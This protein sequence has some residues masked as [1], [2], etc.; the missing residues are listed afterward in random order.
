M[1]IR[2]TLRHLR[3]GMLPAVALLAA[4][5]GLATAASLWRTEAARANDRAF[6]ER[7]DLQRRLAGV[8]E[9][10]GELRLGSALFGRLAARGIIG[11]ESRLEWVEQFQRVR[12]QRRLFE[13]R[14]ELQPQ[15]PL[16]ADIAPGLEGDLD[17]LASRLG[18]SI[19]LL[20]EEDLL[21]LLDDLQE[22]ARAFVRP[23][24]C[25]LTRRPADAPLAPEAGG[26]PAPRLDAQCE[27]D[28]ITL[29]KR[30][31]TVP[32]GKKP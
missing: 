25:T 14:W 7:R 32:E 1:D 2:E 31:T 10:G 3:P 29:R 30:S 24:Q 19:P 27:L 6:A 12:N 22:E 15:R 23:R 18:L 16:E 8:E 28:L 26:G 17:F 5:I 11:E 21:R 20:H 9:E 4:G 13:M